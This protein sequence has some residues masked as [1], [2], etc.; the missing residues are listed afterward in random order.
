MN[1][2]I[3]CL[4]EDENAFQLRGG[5]D[6]SRRQIEMGALVHSRVSERI[7]LPTL[8]IGSK[9]EELSTLMASKMTFLGPAVISPMMCSLRLQITVG[10]KIMNT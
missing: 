8:T 5:D 4:L 2:K 7:W 10:G 6:F 1:H 9:R 3:G